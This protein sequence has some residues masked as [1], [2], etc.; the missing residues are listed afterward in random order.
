[1]RILLVIVA[2]GLLIAFHELGHFL[3]ARLFKMRVDRFSIGFGPAILKLQRG[4][5]NFTIGAVP[6]GGFVKIHGM[7]SEE[8]GVGRDDPDAF[9]NHRAWKRMLVIFAGSFFNYLLAIVLLFLLYASGTHQPVAATIG[10]VLPGSEAARAQLRPGDQI[11]R[12]DGQAPDRW[13][14]VVTAIAAKPDQPV[15]LELLREGQSLRV[16]VRP[17]DEGGVG[18]LGISQQYVYKQL[19]AGEAAIRGFVDANAFIVE[20][21]ALFGMLLRREKGVELSS[22][23]GIVKM[24]SDAAASGMDAFIRLLVRLSVALAVFN[25]LPIPALDGGRLVF[26]II[27]AITGRPVSPKTEALAHTIGFIALIALIIVVAIG[28]VRKIFFRGEEDAAPAVVAPDAGV[29]P[30]TL[31]AGTP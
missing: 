1:M 12:I 23:V 31:D 19:P 26:L 20:N 14:D 6:L 13:L 8:E 10:T 9:F 27:E 30:P 28:D 11:A 4:V 25:L 7:H 15:E 17:R 21:L 24:A 22:P 29:E 2:I 16:V 3:F 18:R 5:T